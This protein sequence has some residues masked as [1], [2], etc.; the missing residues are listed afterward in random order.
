MSMFL[1]KELASSVVN[2]LQRPDLPTAPLQ[3]IEALCSATVALAQA[4]E[5][6]AIPPILLDYLAHLVPYDAAHV[7]LVGPGWQ[8]K[9]HS[10]RGWKPRSN[11]ASC[12][13]CLAAASM[14]PGPDHFF[15]GWTTVLMADR[16]S[17]PGSKPCAG[18]EHAKSY[19]IVPL[20]TGGQTLGLCQVGKQEAGFYTR[21]HVRWAEAVVSQAATALRN[22]RLFKQARHEREELQL[23]SRHLVDAQEEERRRIARDLHD[24]ASQ[25]LTSLNMQLA[26][27][28]KSADDPDA[29]REEVS[30]L[31]ALVVKV[32]ESVHRLAVGLRPP[33]LDSVGLV[34]A[35]TQYC[36]DLVEEQG[37]QIEFEPDESLGRL[38]AVVETA[39][40][41]IVQEALLNVTRHA[42]ATGARVVLEKRANRLIVMVEDD[43][44]GFDPIAST[45]NGRLGLVGMQER[46]GAL[47]G[48]LEIESA[49][50]RGTRL[51]VEVPCGV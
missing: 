5:V 21:E 44:V 22:A 50:G 48:R 18:L 35:L 1:R 3:S 31:S 38:P 8:L 34:A 23:L 2:G 26:L 43:G 47:G 20:V 28:E 13:G 32:M 14:E 39:I 51:C 30:R 45:A 33:C 42:R 6:D 29:V 25:L 7:C 4:S 36:T 24:E 37:L 12:R 15:V 46:A 9:L 40:Y 41:R 19:M 16:R 11:G 10:T 49:P 17:H 27:L